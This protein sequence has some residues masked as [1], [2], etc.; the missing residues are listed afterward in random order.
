LVPERPAQLPAN[1]Q[2]ATASDPPAALAEDQA[3][4]P[5]E[6]Q[7]IAARHTF[8]WLWQKLSVLTSA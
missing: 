1:A 5:A 8:L 4:N 2:S 6:M 7:A 3:V